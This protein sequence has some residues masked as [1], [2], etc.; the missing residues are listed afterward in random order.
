MNEVEQERC[1]IAER[2]YDEAT[3]EAERGNLA[4]SQ[5]FVKAGDIV[6]AMIGTPT[7]YE[8]ALRELSEVRRQAQLLNDVNHAIERRRQGNRPSGHPPHNPPRRR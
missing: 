2:L 8:H 1:L 5:G 4:Q 7:P 6:R 3:A